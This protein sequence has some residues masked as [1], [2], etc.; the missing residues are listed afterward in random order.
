MANSPPRAWEIRLCSRSPASA[1][2][3]APLAIAAIFP[4]NSASTTFFALSGPFRT[5]GALFFTAP[6]IAE[7]PCGSLKHPTK[8]LIIRAYSKPLRAAPAPKMHRFMVKIK[9]GRIFKR[10]LES[11]NPAKNAKRF[12]KSGGRKI[13]RFRV[14]HARINY[15]GPLTALH[16]ALRD[17]GIEP[18]A[19]IVRSGSKAGVPVFPRSRAG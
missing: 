11:W 8:P 15:D 18:G 10:I 12:A 2:R 5:I 4:I 13:P 19:P 3:Q 14:N 9:L 17:G 16:L 1:S 6:M 7:A